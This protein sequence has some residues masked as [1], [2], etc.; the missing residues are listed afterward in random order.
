MDPVFASKPTRKMLNLLRKMEMLY[1]ELK[2]AEIMDS[3]GTLIQNQR[4]SNKV[5]EVVTKFQNHSSI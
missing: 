2:L 4:V 3:I 1:K 5:L